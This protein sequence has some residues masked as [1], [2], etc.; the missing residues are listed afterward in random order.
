MDADDATTSDLSERECWERLRAEA[1]GRLAV[2]GADG[3]FIYPINAIVDH[4]SI[5]FRTNE[6]YKLDS[7]RADPRVAFEVDGWNR[8]DAVA[9]SVI[10]TGTAKEITGLHEGLDVTELG[11]TPWQAGSKPTFIRVVPSAISGR[12]FR[13][14]EAAD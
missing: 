7:M 8:A 14:V 13:R 2:I 9:W 6:G 10:V 5:V 12:T 11:V 4:G 1:Y 3:P